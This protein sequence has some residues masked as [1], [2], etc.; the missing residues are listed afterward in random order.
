MI[1]KLKLPWSKLVYVITNG[2][3]NRT[4]IHI[5]LLK[6]FHGKR[7]KPGD[8]YNFSALQ[9]LSGGSVQPWVT[10]RTIAPLLKMLILCAR[11][12]VDYFSCQ[13]YNWTELGDLKNRFELWYQSAGT[14]SCHLNKMTTKMYARGKGE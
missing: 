2:S 9:Y 6:K 8:G 13:R 4:G 14:S 5:E 7:R 12:T 1:E 10:R 3:P 11:F